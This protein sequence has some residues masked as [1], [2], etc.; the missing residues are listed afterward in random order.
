MTTNR[1]TV[2]KWLGLAPFMPW[3]TNCTAGIATYRARV[4][5]HVIAIPKQNVAALS[6]PDGMLHVTAPSVPG[7]IILRRTP[8][9]GL[10]A[11]S[12]TCTHRGCEV[13]PFPDGFRCPCHG[14]EYEANGDVL[15]GPATRALQ[16]FPVTETEH[17][18]KI[19]VR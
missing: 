17:S 6:Q 19:E 8:D 3:F 4:Q 13:R 7:A 11:V 12:S 15:A 14:S 1:R 10:V 16:R 2:L 18:F 5:E 9:S